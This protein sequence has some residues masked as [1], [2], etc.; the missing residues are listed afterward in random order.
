MSKAPDLF[1]TSS[2]GS[3][4]YTAKDIEV[5][6]GLEPVRRRPG[7]YVGYIL[8]T[9]IISLWPG[10][11]VSKNGYTFRASRGGQSEARLRRSGADQVV[12]KGR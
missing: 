1:D 6:E 10:S 12:L 9:G 7:M 11:S 4:A 3:K 5:L 2:A 8:Q